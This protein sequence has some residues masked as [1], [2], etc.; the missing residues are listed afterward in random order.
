MGTRRGSNYGR[1]DYDDYGRNNRNN[2]YPQRFNNNFNNNNRGGESRLVKLLEDK[3]WRE[4][5][6]DEKDRKR[7]EEE[8]ERKCKEAEA[9][10]RKKD[11][12]A[13]MERINKQQEE[14]FKKIVATNSNNNNNNNRGGSSKRGRSP[15]PAGSGDEADFSS[16]KDALRVKAVRRTQ[17][18]RAPCN[19]KDWQGWTCSLGDAGKIKTAICATLVATEIKDMTLIELAE[20]LA[21]HAGTQKKSERADTFEAAAGEEPPSRWARLDLI[22]GIAAALLK[23]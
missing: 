7:R 15:S 6:K 2:D 16:Y 9:E 17:T 8:D 11:H 1:G 19:P 4:W 3:G 14:V 20:H 12:E 10:Q 22:I 13:M 21:A 23:R 5:E 18:V